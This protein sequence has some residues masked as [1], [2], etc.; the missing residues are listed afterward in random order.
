M[1]QT[2]AFNHKISSNPRLAYAMIR[3]VVLLSFLLIA[4]CAARGSDVYRNEVERGSE[5]EKELG[6]KL[7]V[8]DEHDEKRSE[9]LNAAIPIESPAP[10]YWVKF[11]ATVLGEL[12]NLF[13]LDLT[14]T[15]A[16]GKLLQVPLAIRSIWN[17]DN[18]IDIRFPIRKDLINQTELAISLWFFRQ[19]RPGRTDGM[20]PEILLSNL[21]RIASSLSGHHQ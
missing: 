20:I 13:E 21:K 10:D 7:S 15:D 11:R 16:N 1:R 14:L 17:K 8:Q 4:G 5:L 3:V 18:E 6:Y 12:K 2:F 9:S 19:E